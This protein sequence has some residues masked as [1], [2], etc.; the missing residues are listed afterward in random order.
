MR[1]SE[2]NDVHP[3]YCTGTTH[4]CVYVL[5][6]MFMYFTQHVCITVYRYPVPV[7][8]QNDCDYFKNWAESLSSDSGVPSMSHFDDSKFA[9]LSFCPH[10]T[11]KPT[12]SPYLEIGSKYFLFKIIQYYSILCSAKNNIKLC[13]PRFLRS[14]F[15]FA[16]SEPVLSAVD[17]FCPSS[18][19][20]FYCRLCVFYFPS[21]GVI[22]RRIIIRYSI[23]NN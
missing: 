21:S 4:T 22:F 19:V 7:S 3:T 20:D 13:S 17:I 9:V 16:Q 8:S 6:T 15:V 18:A 1:E 14:N 5:Y 2:T 12:L 23:D 11:P 10:T